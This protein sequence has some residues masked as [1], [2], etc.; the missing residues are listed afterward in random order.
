MTAGEFWNKQEF[1]YLVT[2]SFNRGPKLE[3]YQ[4]AAQAWFKLIRASLLTAPPAQLSALREQLRLLERTHD[5]TRL[6][7]TDEAGAF[8][9]TASPVSV[10]SQGTSAAQ[11]IAGLFQLPVVDEPAWMCAPVYRDALAFYDEQ[12]QLLGVLN[13]CFD[14]EWMVTHTGQRV[15]ADTAAYEGLRACLGRA[16]HLLGQQYVNTRSGNLGTPQSPARPAHQPE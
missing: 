3:A 16:G 5:L 4:Q 1:S 6:S 7:L 13:I 8:H 11:E 2:Y 10:I 15:Q 14:C 12:D 9:L